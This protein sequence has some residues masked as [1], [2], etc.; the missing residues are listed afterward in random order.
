MISQQFQKISHYVYEILISSI[1]TFKTNF[2]NITVHSCNH[3]LVSDHDCHPVTPVAIYSRF[4]EPDIIL[5]SST[6]QKELLSV[7]LTK[8]MILDGCPPLS[9]ALF[10]GFRL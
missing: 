3:I 7:L 4:S 6:S 5:Y 2:L 10:Q 9:L 8:Y 1:I